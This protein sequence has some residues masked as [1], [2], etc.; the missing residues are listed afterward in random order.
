MAVDLRAVPSETAP[1]GVSLRSYAL[2]GLAQLVQ[3]STPTSSPSPE[4]RY[5][6]EQ[7]A[8]VAPVAS[9]A[10]GFLATLSGYLFAP[11]EDDARLVRLGSAFGLTVFEQLAVALAAAVEDD[12]MAGR[13]VAWLQAPI[14]GS[15][16]TFGLVANALAAAP[17]AGTQA[18]HTLVS[19][20]AMYSG[21]PH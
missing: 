9:G 2:A 6:F 16:P 7:L 1:T 8:A 14:A 21:L 20:A 15:R 12:A 18:L 4:Q 3:A 17:G 13:A 19:G 5:L 10:D 11:G